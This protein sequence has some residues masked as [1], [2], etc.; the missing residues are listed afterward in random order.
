MTKKGKSKRVVEPPPKKRATP[1]VRVVEP[2][3][4]RRK[5]K[6]YSESEV[7][8]VILPA[9]QESR[10]ALRYH[11]GKDYVFDPQ[12]RTIEWWHS[13]VYAQI[14]ISTFRKWAEADEWTR[15]RDDHWSY[16]EAAVAHKVATEVVRQQVD[17]VKQLQ[18]AYQIA[19]GHVVGG[20]DSNG[21]PIPIAAPKTFG[22]AAGALVKIGE[23]LDSKRVLVTSNLPLALGG[24]VDAGAPD[25]HVPG[26]S[27]TP[28]QY[29]AMAVAALRAA[30]GTAPP[31][32][33]APPPSDST[34]SD[35]QDDAGGG[36]E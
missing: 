2:P 5:G 36:E 31:E 29:R 18:L 10:E 26:V 28:E 7:A 12:R 13:A 17:E 22:E 6:L 8:R 15:R 34:A 4:K 20:K 33:E 3:S 23:H 27:F 32:S 21:N 1:P 30:A 14:P 19:M 9:P 16:V 24:G 25:A 35:V 11:A